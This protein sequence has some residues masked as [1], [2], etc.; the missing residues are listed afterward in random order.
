MHAPSSD[1]S[2]YTKLERE[3]NREADLF[4]DLWDELITWDRSICNRQ[5]IKI[6]NAPLLDMS[7]LVANQTFWFGWYF[8]RFPIHASCECS[9]HCSL[10]LSDS[11]KTD[12]QGNSTTKLIAAT[13]YS[14]LRSV[15]RLGF[16]SYINVAPRHRSTV[17][18]STH[19]FRKQP[20]SASCFA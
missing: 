14:D 20:A 10:T 7:H 13:W 15:D 12:T 2:L 6:P 4:S 5:Q 16:N 17:Y 3:S 18:T 8:K 9:L 19:N 11:H 1:F